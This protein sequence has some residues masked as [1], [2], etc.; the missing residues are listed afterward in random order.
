MR[1]ARPLTLAPPAT[2]TSASGRPAPCGSTA[3]TSSRSPEPVTAAQVVAPMRPPAPNTATLIIAEGYRRHR[4]SA[5]PPGGS[6]EPHPRVERRVG[7]VDD[8]VHDDDEDRSEQHDGRHDG[9]VPV[10]QRV[11]R[12]LAEAGE[13]EDALGDDG[14]GKQRADV[15]PELGHHRG[16]GGAKPVAVDDRPP[17]EALCPGRPDVVLP[18][19]VEQ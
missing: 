8:G 17:R 3:A 10:E 19:G 15:D 2:A 14:T 11:D 7:D 9:Q 1:A 16:E 13:R 12:E 6:A 5:G 18:E 4:R